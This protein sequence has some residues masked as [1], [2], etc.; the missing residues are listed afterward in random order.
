MN[1]DFGEKSVDQKK[2]CKMEKTKTTETF[3]E[4]QKKKKL[5]A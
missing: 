4:A 5:K 3:F 1:Q 2:F